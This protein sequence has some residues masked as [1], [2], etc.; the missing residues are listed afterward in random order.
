MTKDEIKG[1]ILRALG[2]ISPEVDL[3]Q[4]KH[5]VSFRDQMDM[6]SVDFLNFV[7]ALHK[8][9]HVEIPERNYP[10]LA[11]L[12]GCVEYLA[13]LQDSQRLKWELHWPE[14]K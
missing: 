13:S 10:K 12:H 14:G 6:D 2:A 11:T 4:L 5:D 3:A 7:I 8:R 9:L 1:E